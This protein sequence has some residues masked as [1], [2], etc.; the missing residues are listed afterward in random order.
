MSRSK[1]W[2]TLIPVAL[3]LSSLTLSVV[4]VSRAADAVT[5]EW[6]TVDSEEYSEAAQRAMAKQFEAENPNIK[7]NVIVLPEGGFT[8]KMTTTLGAGQGAPDVAFFWDNNWFPQAL[9]LTPFLKDNKDVKPG[10]IL[11]RLL[12]D[13][14]CLAGQSRRTAAWRWRELCHVQQGP[15]RRCQGCLSERRLDRR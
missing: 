13:T 8:D 4:P 12:E 6:W 9:D 11:P 10:Y 14:R 5:L 3:I 1:H 7:V 2:I 15:F